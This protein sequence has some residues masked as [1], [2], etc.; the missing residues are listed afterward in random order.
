MGKVKII[1]MSLV[2]VL[3]VG[4]T[5]Y[6]RNYQITGALDSRFMLYDNQGKIN[7]DNFLLHGIE[8]NFR[9]IFQGESGDW[10]TLVLQ[11]SYSPDF[12]YFSREFNY[13]YGDKYFVLKGP[14]GQVN[15]KIGKFVVPF[16]NLQYYVSHLLVL[17]PMFARSLGIREDI[18][19]EVGGYFK[20][21]EYDMSFTTGRGDG[22][23]NFKNEGLFIFRL[24]R[25][26]GDLRYGFS[27]LSG[28]APEG[29]YM[30]GMVH[31]EDEKINYVHK[32]RLGFDIQY[33][34]RA[35]TL[36]GEAVF[37]R[38][39][40]I[41]VGGFYLGTDYEISPKI[42]ASLKYDFWDPDFENNDYIMDLGFGLSYRI[43]KYVTPRVAYE[44]SWSKDTEGMNKKVGLFTTQLNL[45]F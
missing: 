23:I 45:N 15:F 12:D 35:F 32:N 38:D 36:R 14:K 1:A 11:G 41:N 19:A 24:G 27:F 20:D 40:K 34:Y 16:G 8:V 9:Y 39:E 28:G 42:F 25:T 22:R 33:P 44:N 37:G 17:Q 30:I 7:R 5:V 43:N 18:G 3:I 29:D 31:K 13:H 2:S 21:Y 26:N 10:A 6:A 4:A